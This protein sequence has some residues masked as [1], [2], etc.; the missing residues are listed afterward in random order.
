[1]HCSDNWKKSKKLTVEMRDL[2]IWKT[3]LFH[4]NIRVLIMLLKIYKTDGQFNFFIKGNYLL[5]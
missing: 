2:F 1:M 3:T 4:I 5:N